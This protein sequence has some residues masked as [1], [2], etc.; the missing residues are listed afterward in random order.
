MSSSDVLR[1]LLSDRAISYHPLIAKALRKGAAT[2]VFLNQLLYWWQQARSDG[3]GVSRTIDEWLDE[4]G[5][6]RREFLTARDRLKNLR[7]LSEVK[8]GY[9]P[10]IYYQIDFDRLESILVKA[11][12][13]NSRD[14]RE[15]QIA[16]NE[17]RAPNSRGSRASI[18]ADRANHRHK[19][20]GAPALPAPSPAPSSPPSEKAGGGGAGVR[21]HAH[22]DPLSVAL[23]LAWVRL[24]GEDQARAAQELIARLAEELFGI[25]VEWVE[26]AVDE[27]VLN[28]GKSPGYLVKILRRWHK[29][30]RISDGRRSH[31][32]SGA[33]TGHAYSD[34]SCLCGCNDKEPQQ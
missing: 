6:S 21:A 11:S 23:R 1:D 7:V 2:A 31:P 13:A 19:G 8:T 32:R 16:I 30:G 22:E 25:P 10:R 26:V 12:A 18:R 28:N 14:P 33:R 27:T 29:D 17:D 9:P 15:S 24:F 5:L 34:P 4:T 20:S 3:Q